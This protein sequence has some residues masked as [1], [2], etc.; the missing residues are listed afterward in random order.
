LPENDTAQLKEFGSAITRLYGKSLADAAGGT[1][2]VTFPAAVSFDRTVAMEWLYEGQHIHRYAIEA[3]D[4]DNGVWRELYRGTTIG[5]KK[6]DVFPRTAARQV[7]LR[8]AAATGS[9]RIQ[10]FQVFHS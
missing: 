9:P 5:H 10:S 4:A 1:T 3:R 8:V 6:I 2:V 7:R